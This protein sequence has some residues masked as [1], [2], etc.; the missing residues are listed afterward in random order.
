MNL[1]TDGLLHLVLIL[2]GFRLWPTASCSEIHAKFRKCD[3][4]SFF[5][6]I[7]NSHLFSCVTQKEIPWTSLSV[8][9]CYHISTLWKTVKKYR[10][11][12][13]IMFILFYS[14]CTFQF[15][16]K[17]FVRQLKIHKLE[18]FNYKLLKLYT[19]K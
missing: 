18:P 4:F 16:R 3:V 5:Y 8:T 11:P 6:E 7:S 12:V 19:F 9:S 17:T 15:S 1:S 2:L 14:Y 13:I 10:S